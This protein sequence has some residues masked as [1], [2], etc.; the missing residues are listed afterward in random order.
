MSPRYIIAGQRIDPAKLER[1][2]ELR[3]DM[4]AAERL[5]WAQL[6]TNRL[7]GFHFR[8]QQ[9]IDGFT[10]DF[11]CHAAGLVIEVDGPVHGQQ[12][13]YDAERDCVLGGRGLRVLRVRNEEVLQNMEH[14]LAR[15]RA[16]CQAGPDQ[17]ETTSV[18]SERS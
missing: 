2:K 3:R 1:A 11:Y 16:A 4:T 6:R 9:I 13:E 17:R 12:A 5:L 15:I 8:R 18:E 10:V 7:D 14:V